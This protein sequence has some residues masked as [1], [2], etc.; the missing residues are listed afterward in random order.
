MLNASGEH[1]LLM[2]DHEQNRTVWPRV[3][4]VTPSY[5]Q[6]AFLEET[7][8]SVLS[9]G[10]PNLEYFVIDGGS[11][12]GSVELIKKYE[13]HIAYWI[14]E[15]DR[16]QSH[17]INKGF[18][19]SSGAILGWLNSDDVMKPGALF[20]IADALRSHAEPAWLIG[21]S[22]LID[23]RS[24]PLRIQRVSRI[25]EAFFF[26]WSD[27]VWIPQQSTFW[28]RVMWEQV[29]PV[30]EDL[31]YA[32][33]VALW[34]KMFEL[35]SPLLIPHV[36]SGYRFHGDCKTMSHLLDSRREV[37]ALL[38]AYR[39][40]HADFRNA[41]K[42]LEASQSDE[43]LQWAYRSYYARQNRQARACLAYAARLFP[44]H[45]FR[46]KW[47]FLA[48]QLTVGSMFGDACGN[49]L[50]EAARHLRGETINVEES[51]RIMK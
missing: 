16:G 45:L 2:R 29:G 14:S 25:D 39:R 34:L 40:R 41:G 9:Q 21:A 44:R 8:C 12:D 46:K 35:A 42:A 17:A 4:I 26:A 30:R 20:A 22:E 3:T 28:N 23:E 27:D 5:N 38:Q 6:R 31:T 50:R 49:Y 37:I 51:G 24:R 36:L 7:L 10:Y 1:L 32:M 47:L 33:D 15:K 48:W 11:S 43:I 18:R 13:R 19:R